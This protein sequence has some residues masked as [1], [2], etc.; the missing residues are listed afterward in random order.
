MAVLEVIRKRDCNL[1]P[2]REVS[3]KCSA[4]EN[5]IEQKTRNK[6]NE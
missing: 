2:D 1:V 3:A 5:P 4:W 6:L